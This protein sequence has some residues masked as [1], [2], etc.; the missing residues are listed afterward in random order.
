MEWIK[1]VEVACGTWE[2][3]V[4][5]VERRRLEFLKLARLAYLDRA[6]ERKEVEGGGRRGSRKGERRDLRVR[7]QEAVEVLEEDEEEDV[8]AKGRK[9]CEEGS[10]VKA[11]ES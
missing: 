4:A 7:F 6:K 3:R 2:D 5:E 10:V 11:S 1:G 9:G 8:A